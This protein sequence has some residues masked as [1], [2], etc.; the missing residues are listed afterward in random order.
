MSEKEKQIVEDIRTIVTGLPE[1]EKHRILGVAEGLAM[2][3]N[4]SK[5]PRPNDQEVQ[6]EEGINA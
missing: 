2:A 3:S 6:W 1:N 5:E 4:M